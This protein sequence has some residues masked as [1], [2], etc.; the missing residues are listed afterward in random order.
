MI[1]CPAAPAEPGLL[2]GICHT[3][4]LGFSAV[5][6]SCPRLS[7]C[8][9]WLRVAL[10]S[11]SKGSWVL[12][13]SSLEPSKQY[14]SCYEPLGSM[15]CLKGELMVTNYVQW[16]QQ[17]SKKNYYLFSEVFCRLFH[18]TRNLTVLSADKCRCVRTFPFSLKL[19]NVALEN[20]ALLIGCKPSHGEFSV[21]TIGTYCVW[22]FNE[23]KCFWTLRPHP[24]WNDSITSILILS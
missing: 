22:S 8:T 10:H 12:G 23:V 18:T 21:F 16:P 7:V 15:Y 4:T 24:D 14:P 2:S 19:G 6:C 3:L 1:K 11:I 20:S 13:C 17:N 5:M 9:M